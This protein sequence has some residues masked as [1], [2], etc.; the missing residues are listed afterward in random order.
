MNGSWPQF[1]WNMYSVCGG[2]S[3]N[4]FYFV[5]SKYPIYILNSKV[6]KMKTVEICRRNMEKCINIMYLNSKWQ[7]ETKQHNVTIL[8]TFVLCK[9]C[10]VSFGCIIVTFVE[11]VKSDS[12][13]HTRFWLEIKCRSKSTTS[14]LC[15]NAMLSP[16][17]K[18]H[19]ILQH[20]FYIYMFPCD[21]HT[22]I[23]IHSLHKQTR[24]VYFSSN[25]KVYLIAA[26]IIHRKCKGKCASDCLNFHLFREES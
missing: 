23:V 9:L 4:G 16:D 20:H 15:T 14:L 19:L 6:I 13:I 12:N 2:F 10:Y 22:C 8:T 17:L 18:V 25:V 11:L 3:F 26:V 21:F 7:N 1:C 5:Q 24:F